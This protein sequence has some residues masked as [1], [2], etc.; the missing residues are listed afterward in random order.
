MSSRD[1]DPSGAGGRDQA[2]ASAQRSQRRVF[3]GSNEMPMP[4]IGNP[5]LGALHIRVIALENLLIALLA[6]ASDQ[7]IELARD[8]ARII[9]PREGITPHPLTI[10]AAAHITDLID[11]SVRFAGGELPRPSARPSPATGCEEDHEKSA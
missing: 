3:R 1:S 11:R 8:M 5:E 2:Q 4:P 10:H 7:Q 9:A 6:H